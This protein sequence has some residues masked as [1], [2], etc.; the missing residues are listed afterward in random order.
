MLTVTGDDKKDYTFEV[1]A[2]A[3]VQLANKPA[4]MDDLK[5]GDKVNVVY[6]REGNKLE[7]KDVYAQRP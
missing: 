4:K 3:K 2:T 5:L 1:G 6:E 7:V